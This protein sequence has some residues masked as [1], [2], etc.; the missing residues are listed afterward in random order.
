MAAISGHVSRDEIGRVRVA[1]DEAGFE[2]GADPYRV[3]LVASPDEAED[4]AGGVVGSRTIVVVRPDTGLDRFA[5]DLLASGADDVVT[6]T[7]DVTAQIVARLRRWRAVDAV[8]ASPPAASIIGDSP[9]LRSA[10]LQLVEVAKYGAGPILL[11]GETGTGKELA[12]RLV[13]EVSARDKKGRLVVLDCTTIV[14]SLSGSELFGHERGAFTGAERAR[15]GAMAGADG[16]TLFLDEI[17]EL[18]LQL[19][20]EVLRVLQEGTYKRVGGDAWTRSNF[21]LVSATNRDL[22]AD[23]QRGRFRSD[24]YHRIASGVVRLP[25]L[26]ERV[27]DIE[28]LFGHFLREATHL[29]QVSVA[30]AV[31]AM[32]QERAFPGNLRELRQL[33]YAVA[34][35][36]A[37][38]GQITPGDVPPRDRPDRAVVRDRRA[39]TQL[40]AG[41][42]QCL[43]VGM[44]LAELKTK[45]GDLAVDL[46]LG[47]SRGNVQRAAG[48]LGV[49]DRAVQMRKRQA[50]REP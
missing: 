18:S 39:H 46:A 26:R 12:A 13:H 29:D 32:L 5:W 36:H 7:G 23:Q 35:R 2:D 10:L 15:A 17:G 50:R 22:E 20:A 16:G 6:W 28:A 30:P 25:P 9:A 3:L 1:L 38:G 24:L 11:V 47:E 14:P 37:G 8:L 49:T 48:M 44:S 34:A 27:E 40:E 42:R 31:L 45:V 43:G 21:R 19:Q 4:V 41:V 33:A